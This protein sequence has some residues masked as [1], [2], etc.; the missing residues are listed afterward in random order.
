MKWVIYILFIVLIASCSNTYEPND[1]IDVKS[2]LLSI[3]DIE[4]YPLQLITSSSLFENADACLLL[5]MFTDNIKNTMPEP[6]SQYAHGYA[7]FKDFN[8]IEYVKINEESLDK[9]NPVIFPQYF[10]T[11]YNWK[12]FRTFD[13]ND[14]VYW[15]Y[16]E[17]EK[18]SISVADSFC[19][20]LH[21]LKIDGTDT[22]DINNP[23][24]LTWNTSA[25]TNDKLCIAFR[26]YT[27]FLDT[28]NS[29]YIKGME[30]EDTGKYVFLPSQLNFLKNAQ[31]ANI[32]GIQFILTRYRIN[33]TEINSNKIVLVSM[34]ES[35]VS[36]YF[37]K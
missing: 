3:T 29:I 24:P 6:N 23:V 9:T 1:T 5:K 36:T 34:V 2:G 15:N 20:K 4:S 16:K 14:G 13:Y 32:A 17:R 30:L 33:K 18:S 27:S 8:D 11:L 31:Y 26:L 7:V 25:D 22:I 35:S 19:S 21:Y 10:Y 37:V 12:G 28:Q